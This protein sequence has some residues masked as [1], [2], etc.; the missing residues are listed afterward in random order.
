MLQQTRASSRRNAGS[1]WMIYPFSKVWI[2]R[3]IVYTLFIASVFFSNDSKTH[4]CQMKQKSVI[5]ALDGSSWLLFR[6]EPLGEHSTCLRPG[7]VSW[8]YTEDFTSVTALRILCLLA[9]WGEGDIRPLNWCPVSH[10]TE[11]WIG[12]ALTSRQRRRVRP[13]E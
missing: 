8:P 7:V 2:S 10:P 13:L 9:F 3:P 12:W 1:K 4:F 6:T 5:D 11:A